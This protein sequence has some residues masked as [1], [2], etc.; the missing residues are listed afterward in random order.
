MIFF[1]NVIAIFVIVGEEITLGT[2][3]RIFGLIESKL[4]Q[5]V[6]TTAN[7]HPSTTSTTTGLDTLG[8][9]GTNSIQ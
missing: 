9:V 7:T 8:V 4:K 3:I 5:R 6:C 2:R 1:H